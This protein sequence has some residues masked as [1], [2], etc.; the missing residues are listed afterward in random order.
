[1]YNIMW[2]DIDNTV[3]HNMTVH[4]PVGQGNSAVTSNDG[5]YI[6]GKSYRKRMVCL[7][8]RSQVLPQKAIGR[9]G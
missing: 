6:G 8:G 9:T 1:M 5:E 3:K 7:D 4:G 2:H